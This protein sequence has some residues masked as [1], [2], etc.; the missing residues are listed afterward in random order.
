[1]NKDKTKK[2]I[3]IMFAWFQHIAGTSFP[4]LEK[5]HQPTKHLNSVWTSDFVRLL[6]KYNFQL[7][8]RQTNIQKHQRENDRFIMDDVHN[9]TSS[10]HL[11]E[12]LN[13]CRLY[14]QITFLSEKN[15]SR[16]RDHHPRRCHWTQKRFTN[17]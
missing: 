5:N 8:L 13:A 11:L 3:I 4:I 17:K 10:I 6:K 12:L 16:R 15:K 2:L 9:Y 14:L 7:K 1:M